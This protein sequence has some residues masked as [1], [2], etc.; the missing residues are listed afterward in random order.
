MEQP[1]LYEGTKTRLQKSK[2]LEADYQDDC[3]FGIYI[4][5]HKNV[6]K[7][8]INFDNDIWIIIWNLYLPVFLPNTIC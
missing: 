7:V 5:V 8:I 1:C 4:L 3:N 2:S 6:L